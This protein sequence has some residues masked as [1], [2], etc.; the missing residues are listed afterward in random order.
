MTDTLQFLETSPVE[1]LRIDHSVDAA[2]VAATGACEYHYNFLDYYFAHPAGEVRARAYLD[3]IDKVAI[4]L[5]RGVTLTDAGV[6][7]ILAWLRFRFY[8]IE[9]LTPEGYAP[10]PEDPEAPEAPRRSYS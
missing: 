6:K 8:R 2:L 1:P 10:V 5:P 4:Y 7:L 9:Y 3:E